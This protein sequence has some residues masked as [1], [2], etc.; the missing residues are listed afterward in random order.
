M[1]NKRR[2]KLQINMEN[3]AWNNRTNKPFHLP[4][5][6]INQNSKKTANS[7]YDCDSM[8]IAIMKAYA[9]K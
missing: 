4:N 3:I 5:C 7:Y 9:R 8:Y 1:F 2:I 6:S